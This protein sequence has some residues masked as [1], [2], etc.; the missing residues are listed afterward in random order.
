M[1]EILLGFCCEF[2]LAQSFSTMRRVTSLPQAK[3]LVK[4]HIF[5]LLICFK[6]FSALNRGWII[7]KKS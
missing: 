2:V 1:G 3:E 4:F 7:L 6:L 5:L